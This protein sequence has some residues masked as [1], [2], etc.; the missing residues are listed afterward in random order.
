MTDRSTRRRPQTARDGNPRWH[1]WIQVGS[2]VVVA[3]FAAATFFQADKLADLQA[4]L[5]S[6]QNAIMA[7]EY[8]PMITVSSADSYDLE[9]GWGRSVAIR[10]LGE[11]VL[12][13]TLREYAFVVLDPANADEAAPIVMPVDCYYWPSIVMAP[14]LEDSVI[15]GDR[16]PGEHGTRNG[17]LLDDLEARI[18]SSGAVG[19]GFRL[20][21]EVF[22]QIEYTDRLGASQTE[23]WLV[24]D[25]GLPYRVPIDAQS[26]LAELPSLHSDEDPLPLDG[27]SADS[28]L[29]YDNTDSWKDLPFSFMVST[30]W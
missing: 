16:I 19:E 15:L 9:D 1:D 17:A 27:L 11:P 25:G 24:P 6:T 26:Q 30:I 4:Q 14:T 10:N 21:A 5:V 23:W 18:T 13:V 8:R 12:D 20:R 3:L 29:R 7:T 22:L 2:A 28:L